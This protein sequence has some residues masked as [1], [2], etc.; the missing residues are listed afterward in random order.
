MGQNVSLQ[1]FDFAEVQGVEWVKIIVVTQWTRWNNGF[2]DVYF[3]GKE[4]VT[5]TT[6]APTQAPPIGEPCARRKKRE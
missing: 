4:H 3:G 6:A 1:E 5:M 2:T